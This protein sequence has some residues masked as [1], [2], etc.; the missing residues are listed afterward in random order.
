[1]IKIIILL[2]TITCFT[3]H[4]TVESSN[5]SSNSGNLIRGSGSGKVTCPDGTQ[6]QANVAFIILSVNGTVQGNWTLDDFDEQTNQGT[7][8]TE[9]KIYDG[10][11]SLNQF[12]VVG[13][14]DNIEEQIKLCNP[15]VFT[16]ISMTGVCGQDVA[17]TVQ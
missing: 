12:R 4:L 3:L 15:H 2:L 11:V 16:P 13:N 1:M 9:G 8:F 14:S 6:N 10:N 5:A 17:I 7:F